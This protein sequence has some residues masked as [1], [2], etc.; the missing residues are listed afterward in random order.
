MSG[1][2]SPLDEARLIAALPKLPFLA[3]T[4]PSLPG[5]SLAPRIVRAVLP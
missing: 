5:W 1:A 4:L 3:A 2:S